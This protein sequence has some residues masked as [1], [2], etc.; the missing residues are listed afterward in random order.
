[1]IYKITYLATLATLV[2]GLMF[3]WIMNIINLIQGVYEPIS[4]IVIAA[5]GVPLPFV[6]ALVYYIN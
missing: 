4:T 2:L 5:I 1:M 6:G 3:G